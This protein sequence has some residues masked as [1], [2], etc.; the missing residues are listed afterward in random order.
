MVKVRILF[1]RRHFMQPL[2]RTGL[3]LAGALLIPCLAP[4]AEIGTNKS[5][6]I[7]SPISENAYLAAGRIIINEPLG[8]DGVL[9]AGSILVNAA[10]GRDVL[11]AGGDLIINA[12][13]GGNARVA[14]GHVT[15]NGNVGGDLVAAGGHVVIGPSARVTG[16]VIAAGGTLVIDGVIDG[17]LRAAGGEVVFNGEVKGSA[18]FRARELQMNGMVNGPATFAAE[19]IRFG[20]AARFLE[21][22]AY[23]RPA[24]TID[25]RPVLEPEATATYDP[26]LRFAPRA[27]PPRD[28]GRWVIFGWLI[29]SFFSGMLL[30]ILL[31]FIAPGYLRLAGERLEG[32]FWPK[33]GLGF[34]YFL[35]T[36]PLALVL[37]L[38][39]VGLPLGFFLLFFYIFSIFFAAALSSAVLARWLESRRGAVWSRGRVLFAGLGLFALFKAVMLVP[40][41]GWV[42]AFIPICAAFGA[43]LTADW[44][45]LTRAD[46]A[47]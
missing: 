23:W 16:D 36:P 28:V 34:L 46:R 24:G 29:F 14:G 21:N 27:Y 7:S 42:V 39:V 10:V 31:T 32:S 1:C 41:L 19:E 15:I 26:D 12:P 3:L 43:L 33:T 40:L 8:A 11:A 13:V 6:V 30:L 37:M 47:V 9:A 45:L 25:F 4:A 35:V 18:R 44:Q 22:V 20:P 5:L 38:T 17:N 2:I